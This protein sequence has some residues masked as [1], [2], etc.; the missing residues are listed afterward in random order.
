MSYKIM[1]RMNHAINKG[2]L[3]RVKTLL[4]SGT[5]INVRGMFGWT[6]LM[7]AAF[8][9]RLAILKEL[10]RRGANINARNQWG[11]TALMYAAIEGRTAVVGELLKRGANKNGVMNRINI[12]ANMKNFITRKHNAVKTISR[13]RKAATMRRRLSFIGSNTAKSLPR[14]MVRK[15]LNK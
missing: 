14:N 10:L 3:N 6:P 1:E 13:Y 5:N 7:Y 8:F 9:G 4:N 15:I 11:Y 12:S 2:N